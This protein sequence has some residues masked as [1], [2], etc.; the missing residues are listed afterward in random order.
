M[1]IIPNPGKFDNGSVSVQHTLP[2]QVLNAFDEVGTDP[3]LLI[4]VC[5][6]LFVS[7]FPVASPLVA[8]FRSKVLLVK[9]WKVMP[10]VDMFW[11]S[12]D[13]SVSTGS[14]LG[15]LF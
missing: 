11:F 5:N 15:A 4:P 14:L 8:V 10:S 13:S 7:A 9:S 2:H 6:S 1:V 3:M 12:T